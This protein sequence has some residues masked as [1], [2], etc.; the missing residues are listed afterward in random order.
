MTGALSV[1]SKPQQ[2]IAQGFTDE[3]I[4]LIK[5]T[6]APDATDQELAL[7]LAQCQRTG[8]DPFSRQIYFIKRGG[9]GSTQVS[10]DGFRVIA[11]RSG[12]MDGQEVAWCGEDGQWTEVWLKKEPPAAA[13]VLVYRKGCSHAFPAIAKMVEYNAG[14]PMWAKM[15]ANQLAKCAEALAL[16]K[17]FPHQLSGLY[18]PDE[19]AQADH[20]AAPQTV[21]VTP[22]TS[23]NSAGELVNQVT[24]E[25]IEDDG[26]LR[27]TRVE[28]RPT[29]TGKDRWYVHLSDGREACTFKQ[30][31]SAL[32]EQL[33]Q[34][35]AVVVAETKD[36][37]WGTDLVSLSK[38]IT[39]QE[40]EPPVQIT[41]ADIPF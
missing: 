13:K 28:K 38:H 37:R 40:P 6:I 9:K 25:V 18:T 24:G 7:F 2:A 4:A 35:A 14:G 8:L 15:P 32:A 20:P 36:G 22:P 30:Q 31:L 39:Y 5:K 3:Q 27:I 11:E 10:I 1:V 29:N 12:E 33:A 17:A 26:Q 34:E 16:R 19:M 23:T 21:I 41:D